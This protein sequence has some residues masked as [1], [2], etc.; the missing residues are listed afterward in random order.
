[1]CSLITLVYDNHANNY[2]KEILAFVYFG[3][4]IFSMVIL[5]F[6]LIQEG[7]LSVSG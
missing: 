1:M 6:P 7:H 3:I 5:F 2:L 4:C